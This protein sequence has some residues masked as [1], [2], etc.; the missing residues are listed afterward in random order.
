MGSEV[1]KERSRQE[2][3]EKPSI[4]RKLLANEKECFNLIGRSLPTFMQNKSIL[5]VTSVDER[6]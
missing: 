3:A 1:L 4:M 2:K 5:N 6:K